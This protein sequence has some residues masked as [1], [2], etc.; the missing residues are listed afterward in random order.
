MARVTLARTLAGIAAGNLRTRRSGDRFHQGTAEEIARSGRRRTAGASHA[1]SAGAPAALAQRVGGEIS[2][3]L[4]LRGVRLPSA[5]LSSQASAK[6]SLRWSRWIS[7]FV[8]D[9]NASLDLLSRM[10]CSAVLSSEIA[11][12]TNIEA[13]LARSFRFLTVM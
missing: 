10:F 9:F 3:N 6:A 8:I 4:R 13:M 5:A 7:A 11:S 1:E 12:G 2:P